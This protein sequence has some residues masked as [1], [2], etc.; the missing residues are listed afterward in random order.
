MPETRIIGHEVHDCSFR[1]VLDKVADK[2]SLLLITTLEHM[3]EQRGRFSHLKKA[4]PGISQRMLTTTL[5]NLERDGLVSRHFFPEIPPRVEYQLTPLGKNLM[6]PV[7]ELID[8]IRT[9]WHQ[10]QSAREEFD[11]KKSLI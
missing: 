7:S 8:W 10:I 11:Q 4:I 3:P 2:W 5:R 9:H 1:S 6:Q